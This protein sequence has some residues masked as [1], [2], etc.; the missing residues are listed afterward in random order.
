MT[1]GL[2]TRGNDPRGETVARFVG[3]YRFA[4][5]P[6]GRI[7]IPARFRKLLAPGGSRSE[8]GNDSKSFIISR[9]FELC[10]MAYPMEIWEALETENASLDWTNDDVR[11]YLRFLNSNASEHS[12]DKQGRI[13][14]TQ[15]VRNWARIDRDVV[16]VGGGRTH[17]EIFSPV[18]YDEYLKGTFRYE[19]AVDAKY[20]EAARK[21]H[22]TIRKLSAD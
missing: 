17:F 22:M 14:L 11:F 9:G 21:A 12:F 10:L 19:N 6:K 1:T 7:N 4:V 13:V 20:I 18:V 15:E 2:F 16:I 3:E 8:G 5:D